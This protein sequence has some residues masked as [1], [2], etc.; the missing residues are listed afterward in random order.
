M[1]ELENKEIGQIR[2]EFIDGTW[3]ILDQASLRHIS[4]ETK[5]KLDFATSE[6]FEQIEAK[7]RIAGESDNPENHLGI[8]V[9]EDINTKDRPM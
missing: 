4:F 7:R 5:T 2:F 1:K 8:E 9:K 3:F 6:A